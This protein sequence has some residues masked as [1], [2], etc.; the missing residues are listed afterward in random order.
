MMFLA[1]GGPNA[2]ID[3]GRASLLLDRL[4]E[5]LRSLG[6]LRRILL[7][8]PDRT[9]ADSGAG[10]LTALLYD[11]LHS[12]ADVDVLPATG[13]HKRMRDEDITAM[14]TGVPRERFLYHDHQNDLEPRGVIPAAVAR[15]LSNGVLNDDIPVFLNRL[16]ISGGYDRII[17]IG[18][19]VPHEVIGIANHCKNIFIGLGSRALIDASHYL[20]AVYGMERIMGRA[21]TPVRA[22]VEYAAEHCGQGLPITYLLTV[23][24]CDELGRMTTRGLFAGD[25]NE[26]YLR[27]AELSRA[28]NLFPLD[29]PAKKIIT[30]MDPEQYTTGWVANKAIYRTRM[31]VADGGELIV[32]APGVSAFGETAAQEALIRKYGFR[33]TPATLEAMRN[34]PDLAGNLGVVAHL[35]H[36]SSEGRFSITYCAGRLS[37]DEIEGV[38][39]RFGELSRF[40]ST[41]L[42]TGWN[43]IDREDVFFVHNPG[44]GLWGTKKL[45]GN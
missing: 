38:G 7:V 24:T 23:R 3:A 43:T 9:R 26:S 30:W 39:F 34:N 37:R 18:Q 31:A 1:E 33:G 45:L 25:D 32:L 12:S 6:P 13:T 28:V 19:L 35:I 42:R 40:D 17:S 27:G 22:L 8:P 2:V 5:Q 20:G 36:G 11:K 16:L 21:R 15:N 44:Q 14:F 29:R 10:E 41:R 4:I